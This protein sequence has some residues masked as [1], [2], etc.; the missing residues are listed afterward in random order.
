MDVLTLMIILTRGKDVV[1]SFGGPSKDN[2][3]Y[4]GWLLLFRDGEYDHELLNTEAIYDSGRKAKKAMEKLV[5]DLR[6]KSI[7]QWKTE[8]ELKGTMIDALIR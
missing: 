8:L 6:S 7:E 5:A 1:C 3:K 4:V 2:G